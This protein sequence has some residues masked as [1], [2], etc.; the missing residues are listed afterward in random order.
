MMRDRR[1]SNASSIKSERRRSLPART[2]MLSIASEYSTTTPEPDLSD[3]QVRRRRAAKL[4]HFFGVDY[5]ELF[6]DVL[7]SLEAGLEHEHK[8]GTLRAEELEVCLENSHGL[9]F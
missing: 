4:T 2:S 6:N 9:V 7:E 3:F 1:V 8:R 5:R